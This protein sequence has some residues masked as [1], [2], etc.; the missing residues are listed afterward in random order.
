MDYKIAKEKAVKYIGLAKKTEQEVKN[1]LT[2]LAVDEDIIDRVIED[3]TSIGYI[4]DVAYANL[5]IKQSLKE[6]KKSK[7]EITQKL[8]QKGIKECIIENSLS[9]IDEDYEEKVKENIIRAKSKSLDKEKL[10][11][12]LYNRGLI[13]YEEWD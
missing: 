8:L 5:Y 2:K 9:D 12:Y 10:N 13:D 1:K 7:F 3:L 4:D 11:K 6:M